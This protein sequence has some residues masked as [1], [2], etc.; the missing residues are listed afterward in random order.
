MKRRKYQHPPKQLQG[1]LWSRDVN[2]LDMEK[3]KPYIIH[4][5]LAYG[6][7]DQWKWLIAQYSLDQIK[8]TFISN[9]YKDYRAPRYNLVT[10]YLL[11]IDNQ[12]LNPARYVKNIPRDI[13]SSS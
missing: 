5:V 12:T 1:V 9:P 13:R 7:I 4:Q 10:K 6:S 8:N 3:D 2:K 11:E